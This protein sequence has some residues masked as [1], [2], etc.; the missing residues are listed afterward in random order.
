MVTFLQSHAQ[1]NFYKSGEMAVYY[2]LLQQNALLLVLS[3]LHRMECRRGV[4][5]R[6]L[7]V[8]L[9][10]AWIVTKREKNVSRFL[11]YTSDHLA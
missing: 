11:Y 5:M 2:S 8:R 7:S 4:A 9:S 3:L 1:F 10:N 6:I